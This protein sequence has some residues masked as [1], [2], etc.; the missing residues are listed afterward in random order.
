MRTIAVTMLA[1]FLICQ[2]LAV[3]YK[4]KENRIKL[5]SSTFYKVIHIITYSLVLIS[6][7]YTKNYI[8]SKSYSIIG[9]CPK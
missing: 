4:N 7:F 6:H 2:S 5:D 1:F 8:L 3:R 9:E